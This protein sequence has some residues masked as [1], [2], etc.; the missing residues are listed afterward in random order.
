MTRLAYLGSLSLVALACAALPACGQQDDMQ[1][2]VAQCSDPAPADLDSC[3]E[4][5]RVLNETDPSPATQQLEAHLIQ[6]QV[7]EREKPQQAD[8]G[9]PPPADDNGVSSYDVS[10]PT[11]PTSSDLGGGSTYDAPPDVPPQDQAPP[12]EQGNPSD[13]GP[14]DSTPPP[15]P[16]AE[17]EHKEH[18]APSDAGP[19]VGK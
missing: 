16:P 18:P 13:V 7:E 4:Q 12:A 11:P 3:I 1:K 6:L 19:G 17:R 8:Q 15:D 2:I 5:V 10:P 14:D 9:T